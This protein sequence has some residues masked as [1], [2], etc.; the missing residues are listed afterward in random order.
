MLAIYLSGAAAEALKSRGDAI[1][2]IHAWIVRLIKA[3]RYRRDI[4][5]LQGMSDRQLSD[6][7]L[8][9]SRIEDAVCGAS[10]VQAAPS[11]ALRTLVC[12]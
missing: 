7:G 2:A 10:P 9:R 1:E 6:I 3:W 8:S 4:R 5:K 12:P 11:P